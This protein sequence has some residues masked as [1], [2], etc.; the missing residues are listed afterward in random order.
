MSVNVVYWKSVKET[1]IVMD[2]WQD[3]FITLHVVSAYTASAGHSLLIDRISWTQWL[4]WWKWKQVRETL[5]SVWVTQAH[6]H[7][8]RCS[9]LRHDNSIWNL[10][11]VWALIIPHHKIAVPGLLRTCDFSQSCG[12]GAV[13]FF[14]LLYLIC[15]NNFSALTEFSQP[16]LVKREDPD[17]RINTIKEIQRRGQSDGRWPQIIIFPEGTCTNRSCLIS[18]KQG[19]R[20]FLLFPWLSNTSVLLFVHYQSSISYISLHYQCVYFC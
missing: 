8:A 14:F 9:R 5:L 10:G 4:S 11:E 1:R 2:L 20:W 16:V 18:F 12:V 17:S 3:G 6:S 19:T 15:D 13:F 7:S